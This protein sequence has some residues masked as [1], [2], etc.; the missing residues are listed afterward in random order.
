MVRFKIENDHAWSINSIKYRVTRDFLKDNQSG[1]QL[2]GEME[3]IAGYGHSC[4]EL[5]KSLKNSEIQ[6]VFEGRRNLQRQ[7]ELGR[8][9]RENMRVSNK[10]VDS[11]RDSEKN[12]L[13]L[14]R[15]NLGFALSKDYYWGQ[16]HQQSLWRAFRNLNNLA[17]WGILDLCM[18]GG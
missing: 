6:Q 1:F 15:E 4:I 16:R 8:L 5:E 13:V 14:N 7:W 3:L 17:Y 9:F 2:P 11:C 18:V 12:L 10:W